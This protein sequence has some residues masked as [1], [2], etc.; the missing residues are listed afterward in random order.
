M[1]LI[2]VTASGIEHGCIKQVANSVTG[3]GFTYMTPENKEKAIKKK[4]EEG[5]IIKARYLNK[6]G[7]GE[8][9]TRPFCL[10]AGEPIQTWTFL[11]EH[12]YDVPKGLVDEVNSKMK[13]IPAGKCD[14]N[15]DNPTSKDTYEEPDHRF[16]PVGF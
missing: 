7:R 5:K 15:G 13:L 8:W 4:K 6:K 16:V 12:V 10:G 2:Q 11:H 3:D 14:E 1:T 9:L